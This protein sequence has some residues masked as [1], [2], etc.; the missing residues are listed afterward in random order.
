VLYCISSDNKKI[1]RSYTIITET[2]N[3]NKLGLSEQDTFEYDID[4]NSIQSVSETFASQHT[5]GS[6]LIYKKSD[7][8]YHYTTN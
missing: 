8:T 2:G 3:T 5:N 4:I 1:I 6:K 7:N